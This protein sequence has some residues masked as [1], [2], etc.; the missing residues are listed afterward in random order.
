MKLIKIFLLIRIDF[1]FLDT[2]L[3]NAIQI[4][5]FYS[6]FIFEQ[7]FI[8]LNPNKYPLFNFW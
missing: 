7:H 3:E 5:L 8:K 2:T 1:I 4:N 6:I